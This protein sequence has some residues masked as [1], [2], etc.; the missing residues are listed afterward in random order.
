VNYTI[1][2]PLARKQVNQLMTNLRDVK[3]NLAEL[4]LKHLATTR[5]FESMNSELKTLQDQMHLAQTLLL[6]SFAALLV[7]VL[8]AFKNS[9]ASQLALQTLGRQQTGEDQFSS[10]DN[11]LREFSQPSHGA[12]T[13]TKS[14]LD[15]QK[16]KRR[17]G[18]ASN[19]TATTAISIAQP[20]QNEL[21]E[22]VAVV[23]APEP[24]PEF[25]KGAVD[26][27]TQAVTR[28]DLLIHSEPQPTTAELEPNIQMKLPSQ[29]PPNG[30]LNTFVNSGNGRNDPTAFVPDWMDTLEWEMNE[31][32]WDLDM[33]MFEVET[34][35]QL[36]DDLN[37]A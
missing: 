20:V 1:V 37:S 7:A 17:N 8:P 3:R 29:P 30:S 25:H 19:V 22:L 6:G 23:S 21:T 13:R 26:S 14:D 27:E 28:K 10:V 36:P 18:H 35:R 2:R 12:A 24:A 34:K 15:L 11:W 5:S 32:D 33:L 4:K 31:H 16:L 9:L